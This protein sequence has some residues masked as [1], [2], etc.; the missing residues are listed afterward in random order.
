[1]IPVLYLALTLQVA[2]VT[3]SLPADPGPERRLAAAA[4]FERS[5]HTFEYSAGIS[6]AASRLADETLAER[7]ANKADRAHRLSD[8]LIARTR[9]APVSM[10]DEAIQCVAEPLA[11]R[12][13]VSELIDLK[14]FASSAEG[15]SF[16]AYFVATQPWLA[17]FTRPVRTYLAP[18]FEEDLA[19]VMAEPPAG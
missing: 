8:R 5:P 7:N 15:R 17:C 3:P 13:D 4:L 1:M 2:P 10:I 6:V 11:I 12:L 14:A 18:Y 9:A 16:W 19:A